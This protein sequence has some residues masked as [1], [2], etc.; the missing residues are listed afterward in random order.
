MDDL[1]HIEAIC[2]DD[3]IFYIDYL[4]FIKHSY[5]YTSPKVIVLFFNEHSHVLDS[6]SVYLL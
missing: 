2:M 4:Y 1:Y 3:Q 6:T 5:I